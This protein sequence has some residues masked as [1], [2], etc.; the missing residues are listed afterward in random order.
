MLN[1]RSPCWLNAGTYV[2]EGDLLARITPN[3]ACSLE[4]DVFPSALGDGL[5]IA[6]HRTDQPFFDIGTAEDFRR[7]CRFMKKASSRGCWRQRRRAQLAKLRP[8]V[9]MSCRKGAGDADH[10]RKS[11]SLGQRL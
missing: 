2:I 11:E 3:I 1:Q 7:F 8:K 6:A 4:H 5:P 9:R 10:G